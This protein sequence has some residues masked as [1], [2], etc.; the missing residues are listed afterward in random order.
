MRNML[1]Q[2]EHTAFGEGILD[3]MRDLKLTGICSGAAQ[4]SQLVRV[5]VGVE[6]RHVGEKS[7]R[8]EI[9]GDRRTVALDDREVRRGRRAQRL[10]GRAVLEV[11]GRCETVSFVALR[12]DDGR[13]GLL[14]LRLAFQ[15]FDLFEKT[16]VLGEHLIAALEELFAVFFDRLKITWHSIMSAAVGWMLSASRSLSHFIWGPRRA[17]RQ[18]RHER[19]RALN[20][21][22]SASVPLRVN[23]NW[24]RESKH[25]SAHAH[26]TCFC[27]SH[28]NLC[29]FHSK[30][31][32][33]D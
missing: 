17:M 12:D 21:Q 5:V 24:P 18:R 30:S 4:L 16:D 31:A 20:A 7:F 23:P 9:N 15:L 22:T 26:S 13:S 19:F 8:V 2:R 1:R 32:L 10:R 3:V 11:C 27:P 6:K 33:G 25:P 28:P 14:R 29:L